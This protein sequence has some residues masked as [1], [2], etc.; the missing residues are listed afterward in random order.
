[1][2]IASIALYAV[3]S[4]LTAQYLIGP[5]IHDDFL[6]AWSLAVSI[7]VVLALL[8][9]TVIVGVS[10]SAQRPRLAVGAVALPRQW[11]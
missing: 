7:V 8:I 4:A 10:V 6:T 1:M 3:T 5:A 9:P 11:R 2:C